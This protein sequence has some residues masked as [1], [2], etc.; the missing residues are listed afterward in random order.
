MKILSEP[1]LAEDDF[2][3]LSPFLD[4]EFRAS[5]KLKSSHAQSQVVLIC[6]K[7]YSKT[8]ELYQKA[9]Y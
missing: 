2:W 4:V 5:A 6:A 7:S 3:T 8:F 9:A 1:G